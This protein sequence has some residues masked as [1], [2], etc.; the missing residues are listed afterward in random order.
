VRQTFGF[1]GEQQNV[2]SDANQLAGSRDMSRLTITA[3]KMA[4][5]DMFDNNTY[6][7]DPRTQFMNW[8]L[9]DAGAYDYVAD[10]KGYTGGFV[11]ELNQK[12]WAMRYGY[13]FAP[14]DPNSRF[15]DESFTGEGGHN[16]ELEE[17]YNIADRLGVLRILG[18]ANVAPMGSYRDTLADPAL[19]LNIAATRTERLKYGYVL[20]MEQAITDDLGL[21]SRFS[22][23][24][25]QEEI[26]SYTDIDQSLS[27]GASLK[28]TKW[29]R[30]DDTVGLAG[31]IN[32]LSQSQIAFLKAGGVGIVIGDGS[33]TYA[34]EGII[35]TYYNYSIFKSLSTTFDYQFVDNPAYN[36]DRGP[37]HIFAVRA[38]VAF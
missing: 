18:F 4:I 6:S 37:V 17:R 14:K 3:G 32:T 28:G 25:G 19:D 30:P 31:A 22:W 33:L 8:A 11:A 20:N 35:E 23:N 16:L 9:I 12:A 15:L 26:S 10:Q 2:E 27:A 13:F 36:Q 24:D 1:G 7:H 5:T 29:D 34:P 21:F 38:H